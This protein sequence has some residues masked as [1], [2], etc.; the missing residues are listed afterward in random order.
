MRMNKNE[1]ETNKKKDDL[2]HPTV[3]GGV[4]FSVF[5]FMA[6]FWKASL[7]NYHKSI[8]CYLDNLHF[9]RVVSSFITLAIYL[10][11]QPSC[12]VRHPSQISLLDHTDSSFNTATS[13]LYTE[14]SS[15]TT[16][17]KVEM[18]KK[19]SLWAYYKD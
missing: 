8:G 3:G 14:A 17:G 18:I 7:L 16:S 2:R 19:P 6:L 11:L 13:K 5:H 4:S 1:D 9:P 10:L 15:L 12:T